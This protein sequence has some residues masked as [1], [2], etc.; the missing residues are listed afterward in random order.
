MQQILSSDI[1]EAQFGPT[2]LEVLWQDKKTRFIT[3]K[4]TAS[5][6]LLELSWVTFSEAGIAAFPDIHAYVTAG[7]SM[8]K[9]FSEKGL[10]FER[11]TRGT[12]HSAHLHP[13]LTQYFNKPGLATIVDVS[14]KVG[15][16][17]IPYADILEI[18]S[19]AVVW[20][21]A[22]AKAPEAVAGKV[23]IFAALLAEKHKHQ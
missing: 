5:G 19:P 3:T 21:A 16:Q 14:V 15:T 8:G 12:Y 17:K 20:P 13:T 4:S 18:Y 9:A 11:Q 10:V 1:L 22:A 6:Q 7:A 23:E 2:T